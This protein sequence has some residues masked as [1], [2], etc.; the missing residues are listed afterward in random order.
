MVASVRSGSHSGIDERDD[1][2]DAGCG[3]VMYRTGSAHEAELILRCQGAAYC[4]TSAARAW[5]GQRS[6]REGYS[7]TSRRA[8]SASAEMV[9]SARRI[10]RA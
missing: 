4:G 8:R 3:Q 10:V 9:G 6:T 5:L 1:A 7:P 2:V